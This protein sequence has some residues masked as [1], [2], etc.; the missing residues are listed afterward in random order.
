M[1]THLQ[2][3]SNSSMD[4]SHRSCVSFSTIDFHEHAMV[5]GDHPAT[6]CGPSL[7]L[8]WTAQDS[9]TFSLDEYESMKYER[10]SGKELVM[11]GSMRTNLL[12]ESGYT[13]REI[14]EMTSKRP[15]K[16]TTGRAK[17]LVKLS[18]FRRSSSNRRQNRAKAAWKATT[19][20]T[21]LTHLF[22]DWVCK[23]RADAYQLMLWKQ[24]LQI[25]SILQ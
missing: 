2:E 7:E 16:A 18:N 12:L 5:L 19:V 10:R 15:Q 23:H 24:M 13:M 11:S 8:D 6:S 4:G 14:Q 1:F 20:Y 22:Q 9:A 21:S 3:T 25:R 17:L